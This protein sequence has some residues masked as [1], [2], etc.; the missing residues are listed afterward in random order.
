M[1]GWYNKVAIFDGALTKI[2]IIIPIKEFH[3]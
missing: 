3:L 1:N 2:Q